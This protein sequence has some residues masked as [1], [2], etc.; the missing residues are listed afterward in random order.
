VLEHF[1]DQ[2]LQPGLG[3]DLGGRHA[4][5]AQDRLDVDQGER[6]VGEHPLRRGVPQVVQRPVGAQHG[7]RTLHDRA[8]GVVGQ[9]PRLPGAGPPDR[10][11]LDQ[12]WPVFGEV[13]RQPGKRVHAR[14]DLLPG[15]AALAGHGDRAGTDVE[16]SVAQPEQ[17][18]G[19]PPT[20]ARTRSARGHD[21]SATPRTAARPPR[22]GSPARPVSE[23]SAGRS[24]GGGRGSP[25]SGCGGPTPA[26]RPALAAPGPG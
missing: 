9:R 11:A 14:R 16:I 24:P 26:R 8:G 6:R 21:G 18:R 17:L 15:A 13:E 20:T 3:V 12:R 2:V 22:P 4:G 19:A 5:V 23:P 7:V 1:P 25:P 10:A